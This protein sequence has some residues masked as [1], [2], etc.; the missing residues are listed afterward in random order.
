[1]GMN[2]LCV[3]IL[4]LNWVCFSYDCCC[5]DCKIGDN[6]S[7][8]RLHDLL[9]CV[10]CTRISV[11]VIHIVVLLI[12]I[13]YRA[14]TTAKTSYAAIWLSQSSIS[15]CLFS[16]LLLFVIFIFILFS[17]CLFFIYSFTALVRILLLS[18]LAFFCFKYNISTIQQKKTTYLTYRQ[19]HFDYSCMLS[20][21]RQFHDV[22]Y[23]FVPFSLYFSML[24][25]FS[26]VHFLLKKYIFGNKR[27]TFFKSQLTP[28]ETKNKLPFGNVTDF[29]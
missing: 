20:F 4:S 23:V 17:P 22:L 7:Y 29:L 24:S 1:M 26:F 16:V 6:T 27:S 14:W 3:P 8:Y 11:H 21:L 19:I 2:F 28:K 25:T 13:E 10:Q 12:R 15:F 5:F 18:M 9:Q